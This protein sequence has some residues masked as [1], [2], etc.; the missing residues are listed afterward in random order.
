LID[1]IPKDAI[2]L[3]WGY[4]AN[5]P[6][7]EEARQFR[8]AGVEF[9]VCPGTSSWCSIAGR[10]DNMLANIRS[11]ADA[12]LKH[13]AAGFLN[14]DWGDHGHLQYLPISYPGLAAGAAMSWCTDSNR[15]QPLATALDLHAFSDHAA[16][17]GTLAVDLG[18]VYQSVG[19]L[20]ANRSALF[21]ILV[22]SSTHSDPM[23]GMTPAGLEAAEVAIAA[24]MHGLDSAQMDLPDAELIKSE[25][26]NAAAM[27]RHAC[28]RGKWILD[29]S[30]KNKSDLTDERT[31]IIDSHRR[32]WL[33]RNRP[34]GLEDSVA[35]LAE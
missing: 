6:F 18:N 4:E 25:F 20:I 29:T 17:M 33:A 34:G 31:A 10:T 7:D 28:R 30:T 32:C 22:P 21:N 13:G 16:V 26:A 15:D 9:Y 23:N 35:R 5:H 27:L 1:Q 2:A 14:T 24:A 3:N 19:K 8:E 12:G 11:A